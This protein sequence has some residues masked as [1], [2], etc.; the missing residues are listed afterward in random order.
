MLRHRCPLVPLVPPQNCEKGGGYMKKP[1]LIAPRSACREMQPSPDL[2][3]Y[4]DS[5]SYVRAN[6]PPAK[7]N[8]V[9][10]RQR[11]FQRRRQEAGYKPFQVLLPGHVY[12]ELH[13]LQCEG[14]T[15]AELVER[16][17]LLY[18]NSKNSKV[19]TNKNESDQA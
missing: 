8:D 13:A 6:L 10:K 11:A 18:N 19:R 3:R 4:L 15:M 14:E 7:V 9:A 2:D 1:V 17:L 12:D 5:G 16:L